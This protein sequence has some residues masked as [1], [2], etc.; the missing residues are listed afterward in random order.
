[1]VVGTPSADCSLLIWSRVQYDY[2]IDR[3][4]ADEAG[5]KFY[6]ELNAIIEGQIFSLAESTFLDKDRLQITG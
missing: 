5:M 2:H 4:R 1:M 6:W 3:F